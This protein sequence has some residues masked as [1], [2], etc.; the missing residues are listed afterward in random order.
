MTPELFVELFRDALWMVL[1]LVCAIVIPSLLIGL[2]V[3]VFQAATSINEQTLSFLPRLVVTLLA[4]MAF[5]HWG[6]Q[7][8]MGFFYEIIERLPLI[9]W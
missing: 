2:V 4:L 6:T 9:L 8:M 3:A 1:I 5:A 7:M